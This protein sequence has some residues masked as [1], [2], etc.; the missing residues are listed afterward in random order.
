MRMHLRTGDVGSANGTG[1]TA[2]VGLPHAIGE[3]HVGDFGHRHLVA[4]IQR[5]SRQRS[6]GVAVGMTIPERV[7]HDAV[8]ASDFARAFEIGG[9]GEYSV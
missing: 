2:F 9:H 4:S 8:V 1:V 5:S 6:I 7:E 3:V